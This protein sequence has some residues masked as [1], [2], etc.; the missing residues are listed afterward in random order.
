MA[1]MP[2]IIH[3]QSQINQIATSIVNEA[4]LWQDPFFDFLWNMHELL[5]PFAETAGGQT[6]CLRSLKR[7]HE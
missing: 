1:V 4:K 2:S 6:T 5:Q 3:N 7:Q